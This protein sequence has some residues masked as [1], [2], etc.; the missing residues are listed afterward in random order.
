MTTAKKLGLGLF[1]VWVQ[2]AGAEAR[3][4][5][6][7][8]S[9]FPNQVVDARMV[10]SSGTPCSVKLKRSLGPTYGF[11]TAERPSHGSVAVGDNRIT[12]RSRPGYVGAD[13]FVFQSRG[14]TR[15][16][17]PNTIAARIRVT[18]TAR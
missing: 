15:Q 9:G 12:Y 7:R 8:F 11:H 14:E 18:V 2:C 6:E 1:I 5:V 13:S 10:V 17:N 16:G 3:C 4:S